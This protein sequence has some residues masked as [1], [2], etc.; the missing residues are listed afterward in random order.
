M[1]SDQT[2]GTLRGCPTCG[3][4]VS[5]TELRLRD[6]S[7]V[8]EALPGK[9]GGMDIDFVLSSA[10]TG[11]GLMLEMK[12]P[13]GFVSTGARLTY[14]EFVKMGVDVWVLRGP[15]ADGNIVR[16]SLSPGGQ[17]GDPETLTLEDAGLKVAAWWEEA[18]K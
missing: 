7:W 16:T 5:E 4:P 12:P 1:R 8:N 18:S 10:K 2:Y 13:G 6:F 14:R 3:T 9:V 15:D 11:R 17:E